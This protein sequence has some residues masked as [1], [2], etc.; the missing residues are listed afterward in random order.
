MTSKL[1]VNSVRHTGA[2]SD[3]ITMDASGNVTFP[4]NATC[5]GTATGFGGGIT[6]AQQFRQTSTT[7]TNNSTAY[8][9]SGWEKADG[10]AQ[11]GYGSFADPSSGIFT[12]PTTGFYLVTFQ[13]YFEDAGFDPNCQVKIQATTNDSSYSTISTTNF[14]TTNDNSG[15]NYGTGFVTSIVDVTDVTQVKVRFAVFSSAS[16]SWDGSSSQN[17]TAG[18]FIRLGDT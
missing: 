8:F 17:R 5:S 2:S 13:S 15:Y 18:T 11:N 14:G 16:V 9:T 6:V 7:A 1:I 10:T 12:F 3:A 4:G